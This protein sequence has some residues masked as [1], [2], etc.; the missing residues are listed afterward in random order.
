VAVV[1][2]RCGC[3]SRL[4]KDQGEEPPACALGSG[5]LISRRLEIDIASSCAA[6]VNIESVT[7]RA[8]AM[9]AESNSRED[10]AI[11][12]PRNA[13]TLAGLLD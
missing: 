9:S 12:A 2:R 11:V 13:M 6:T 10:V 3:A 7:L 5:S 1:G 8:S 4:P